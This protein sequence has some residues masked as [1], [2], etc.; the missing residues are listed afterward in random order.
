MMNIAVP[1]TLICTG[2]P[3]C[4]DPQTN[5]GKVTVE[6]ALKLVMMKS[7]KESANASSAPAAIPGAAIGSVT[8]TKVC[9]GPAYR[10]RAASSS[11]GSIDMTRALTAVTT[12]LRQN[13]MCAMRIVQKPSCAPMLRKS[14]SRD[15]AMTTSGIAIGRKISELI[16]PRARKR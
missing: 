1:M 4:A 12:K 2:V 11:L 3:R 14:V 5:M 8:R 13:M 6:P 16:A 7:S 15:A 9:T 10:S